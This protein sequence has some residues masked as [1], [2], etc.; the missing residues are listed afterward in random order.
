ME[1]LEISLADVERVLCMVPKVNVFKI[2]PLG[3]ADG[4]RC[5]GW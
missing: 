2:P 1:E 3:Q 5:T 4:Y